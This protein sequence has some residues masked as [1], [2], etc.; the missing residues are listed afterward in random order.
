MSVNYTCEFYGPNVRLSVN[1][2]RKIRFPVLGRIL[3]GEG[4]DVGTS[5]TENG[6][7]LTKVGTGDCV[8]R[9]CRQSDAVRA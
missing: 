8:E 9:V 2:F 4:V 3:S 5:T 1:S 6:E 7:I